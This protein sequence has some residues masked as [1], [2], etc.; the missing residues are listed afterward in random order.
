[1]KKTYL[2]SVPIFLYFFT[3]FSQNSIN[4]DSLKQVFESNRPADLRLESCAKLV[5]AF[6]ELEDSV[7]V[8]RYIDKGI[9]LAERTRNEKSKNLLRIKEAYLLFRRE[10]YK[11]AK[12]IYND[13]LENSKARGWKDLTAD[14]LNTLGVIEYNQSNYDNAKPLLLKALEIRKGL[15]DTKGLGR[16]K[17]NLGRVYTHQGDVKKALALSE[18]GLT[19]S[20]TAGDF[21]N[22][23]RSYNDIG[24]IYGMQR[25]L[26]KA[27]V[28]F[29]KGL[30]IA[31]KTQILDGLSQTY[32]NLG[33]MYQLKRDYKQAERYYLKRIAI[34]EKQKDRMGIA[35]SL[36]TLASLYRSQGMYAK[37]LEYFEKAKAYFLDLG[38]QYH[39]AASYGSIAYIYKQLGDNEKAGYFFRKAALINEEIKAKKSM[40]NNYNELG[41]LFLEQRREDSAFYYYEK[42]FKLFEEIENTNALVTTLRGIGLIYTNQANLPKAL[43]FYQKA[44]IKAETAKDTLAASNMYAVIADVYMQQDNYKKAFTNYKE[45]RQ[46]FKL[47]NANSRVADMNLMLAKVYKKQENYSKALQQGR[48]ALETYRQL[49]DRCAF[50]DAYLTLAQSYIGLKNSDL[51][52]LYLN[53]ALKNALACKN[54]QS[55]LLASVYGELGTFYQQRRQKDSAFAAYEAALKYASLSKNQLIMKDAAQAIY[56]EYEKRGELAKAYETFKIYHDSKEALYN[57]AN[58]RALVQQEYE[59]Q[60]QE[61]AML[62]QQKEAKLARQRWLIATMLIACLAFVIIALMLYRNYRIKNKANKLLK[63]KNAEISAQRAKLKALDETKSRFFANI[64]HELRTPLTLISSPLQNLLQKGRE[65]FLPSTKETL[66]LMYRNAEALKALVNDILALSKLESDKMNLKLQEVPVKPMLTRIA[67]NF[68]SFAMVNGITYLQFFEELP[69]DTILL[70]AGKTEKIINNLLSNATKHTPSG[71]AVTMV[72]KRIDQQLQIQVKDT[73][74]GINP[75]DLPFIFDRFYQSTQPDAPLQGG[76][77]IGLALAKEFCQFMGGTITVESE[78][79]EGS[80]FTV[81]LPYRIVENPAEVPE[82][83]V[84]HEENAYVEEINVDK[85]KTGKGYKILIVEDHP[86]MQAYVNGLIAADHTTFLASNGKEAIK[87]LEQE[88]VDLIISDVMMPEM[89]G[90]ALLTHLK[91]TDKYHQIPVI[92]LTALGDESHKLQALTIGVDDY[93]TKPFSPDELLVRVHN[94]L[95]RYEA[96]LQWKKEEEKASV[97]GSINGTGGQNNE[98]HATSSPHQLEVAWLKS[99]EKEI[100]ANLENED[101]RLTDLATRYNLSYRQFLRRIKKLTGLSVKQYQQEIALQK[102]REL[103]EEGTYGNASA[104]AYSIGM[105]H[106]TRFSKLYEARFGKKPTEYFARFTSMHQTE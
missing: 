102:A 37:S 95:E 63:A 70:D 92:M 54:V 7:A 6:M 29:H 62:Q 1:M 53:K 64:S 61:S 12:V 34:T 47:I 30:E 98:D 106:V 105:S 38:H 27:S 80:T 51:T 82:T 73:G 96:R 26:E 97:L 44:L 77:G 71:G 55:T 68:N 32:G 49:E 90:Y 86:D 50:G 33:F 60:L 5:D 81:H 20:I 28:Y 40:A 21:K 69:D 36:S 18:E 10:H 16:S 14:C 9:T 56:P 93:L 99:V 24:I 13:V 43:K 8:M 22:I 48:T 75:T 35:V 84:L 104:V 17:L 89:D 79:N 46:G 88:A 94:L 91:N 19:L 103:L 67:S 59:K 39:L 78:L 65:K 76:T 2:L 4:T 3:A 85:T 58:T 45:A 74:P 83:E 100:Y 15:K 31:E 11:R 41:G 57:E 25:D 23:I 66:Q 42:A 52:A 72:A 101:F 87:V